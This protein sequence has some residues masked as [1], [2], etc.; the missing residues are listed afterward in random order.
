MTYQQADSETVRTFW[1]EAIV[2]Q[3]WHLSS[4]AKRK[5][6]AIFETFVFAKLKKEGGHLLNTALLSRR[7]PGGTDTL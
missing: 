1:L 4:L 7:R 2:S 3:E 6:R 5:E